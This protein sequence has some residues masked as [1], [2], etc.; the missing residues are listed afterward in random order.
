MRKYGLIA[1][2]AVALAASGQQDAA[3]GPGDIGFESVAERLRSIETLRGRFVQTREVAALSSALESRGSF[4]VSE[5]GLYWEQS[6]PFDSV[7]IASETGLS[8]RVAGQP[9]ET[10]TS[11]DYPVAASISRVFLSIF[12]GDRGQLDKHF[13]VGFEADGER[14]TMRLRPRRFPLT[15]AIGGIVVEGREYLERLRIEGVADDVTTI[16]LSGQSGQPAALTAE[17]RELF[18]P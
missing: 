7:L 8:Q 9:F 1:A 12:K 10:F 17:E 16:E 14:W 15:E 2:L 4:I 13:D 18:E 5:L 6:E 11:A 3:G